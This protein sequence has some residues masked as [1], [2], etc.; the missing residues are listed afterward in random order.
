MIDESAEA[1]HNG[2]MLEEA[3]NILEDDVDQ[4]AADGEDVTMR[5]AE[6][7]QGASRA[8]ARSPTPTGM[9]QRPQRTSCTSLLLR[10]L[11]A[12]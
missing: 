7:D 3:T 4:G 5:D 9:E 11:R 1:M 6:F 12:K 8:V 2:R 10:R